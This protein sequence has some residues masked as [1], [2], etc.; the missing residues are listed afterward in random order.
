MTIPPSPGRRTALAASAAAAAL[1]VGV[2]AWPAGAAPR[3]ARTAGTTAAST[4][5]ASA[6]APIQVQEWLYPGPVGNVT[7]SA[8]AEYADGRVQNGILKAEYIDIDT[9]GSPYTLLASNP[10]YACNG[11]STANAADVKA[12]S[13]QQYVTVSLADLPSE[14]ALTGTKAK[15]AAAISTITTFVKNIGFTGAD[16]DFENYWDW[17]GD[18]QANYYSFLTELAAGLHAAGLKLQ[19]EGPPDTTTGFNYG[20]VLAD[21]VD[22]VVMMTYDDEYQS[23]VGSTCLA[24][25]PYAWMQDL[26]TSAL[27]QIPAAQQSRF[28]AGLPAEAYAAT[29]KCQNITGNLTV[30]DMTKAP[31]Y[32]SDP[33]VIASR[34][35]PGSGEIRWSSSGTFY[36]YVDQTALDAKLQ[37][38]RNLGITHVSVWTLGGGNAWFSANALAPVGPTTYVGAASGRCMDMP[39]SANSTRADVYDCDGSANQQFVHATDNTLQVLGKC[40]DAQ[41][42]KTTAGTPVILYTCNG[43]TNQQWAWRA[44]GTFV[45]VQSGLCLD[46]T[47][48]AVAA[49]DGTPLELWPC[50]GQS[51]QKWTAS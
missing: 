51:N 18:D 33:A 25:S 31:G 39:S 38:V 3:A 22:Q 49:A 11:Y 34:R 35:D 6:A 27:A 2:A 9:D 5:T 23:P 32:S 1:L 24:F 17:T 46:V 41:G 48:G 15:R 21:G 28:V 26:L 19:V 50:T 10:A 4:T 43:G 40:L 45:G 14:E 44:D 7:C 16:V 30:K 47:G 8:P 36:D 29:N 13:A 42:R 37:L 12:H 20:T